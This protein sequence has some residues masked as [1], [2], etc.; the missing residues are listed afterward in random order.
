M[1]LFSAVSA[2]ASEWSSD[3]QPLQ[4]VDDAPVFDALAFDSGYWPSAT[5]PIAI[6][7]Y[8]TPDGGVTTSLFG[9]SE[10]EWPAYSHRF[11]DDPGGIVE[12]DGGITIGAEIQLDL[13]GVF[14]GTVPLVEER[15]SFQD[16]EVVDGL[17]LAPDPTEDPP[18][19]GLGDDVAVIPPLDY[20]LTVVPGVDLVI[21]ITVTP[22]IDVTLSGASLSGTT[23]DLFWIQQAADDWVELDPDPARPGELGI[24]ADW[25]ADL[26]SVVSLVLEP[27]ISVGTPVGDFE[28][29][30]FPIPLDLATVEERRAAEPQFLVHPLPVVSD[31]PERV[32]FGEVPVG[33]QA[34]FALPV[35]D[36][37]EQILEGT[38]TV[39]GGL[40]FASWPLEVV[41]LPQGSDGLTLSF[42]PTAPGPAEG[43]VWIATN[44]PTRPQVRI[45]VSGV[46]V[47]GDV[48]GSD[49]IDGRDIGP[50][51]FCGCAS[52]GPRGPALLVVPVAALALR[53]R[54]S[55]DRIPARHAVLR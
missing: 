12:L 22:T 53:R 19:L 41:A 39:V 24:V 5:D 15:V 11:A 6:R 52:P 42:S 18:V 54:S 49:R 2:L 44:D 17:L 21:G 37:G 7:F 16:A 3:P 31:L 26:E 47:A 30:S 55:A 50:A 38:V 20:A 10:L 1:L 32:D 51:V 43:E 40:E 8:V 29:L 9:T 14:T 45:A 27:S 48:G 34:S 36:V 35:V 25:S 46:G 13:A 33:D 4:V 23:T 28:L